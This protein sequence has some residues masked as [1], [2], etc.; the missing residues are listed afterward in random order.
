MIQSLV[1]NGVTTAQTQLIRDVPRDLLVGRC[2]TRGYDARRQTTTLSRSASGR[3]KRGDKSHTRIDADHVRKNLLRDSCEKQGS[4]EPGRFKRRSSWLL[5][6]A[7]ASRTPV[8]AE[9][10]RHTLHGG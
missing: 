4:S 9:A 6:G 5:G 2:V 3:S 7:V 10:R 1:M 8:E